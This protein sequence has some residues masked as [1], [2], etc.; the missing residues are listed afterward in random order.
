MWRA[1]F[2]P[3]FV[4]MILATACLGCGAWAFTA[5]VKEPGGSTQG[6]LIIFAA[7]ALMMNVDVAT[8]T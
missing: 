5:A 8:Q 2:L 7:A 1:F 6:S 3:R 4:A